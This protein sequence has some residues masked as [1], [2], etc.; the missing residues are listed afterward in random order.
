MQRI[1]ITVLNVVQRW[2]WRNDMDWI[3]I[4]LGIA[5]FIWILLTL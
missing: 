3:W 5:L 4:V 1:Y 2:I